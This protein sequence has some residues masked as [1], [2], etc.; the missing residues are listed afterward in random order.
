MKKY[1]GLFRINLLLT[2]FISFFLPKLSYAYDERLDKGLSI[3]HADGVPADV[4]SALKENF[5][6]ILIDNSE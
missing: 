2:I 4:L 1:Q 6:K 3:V 5:P